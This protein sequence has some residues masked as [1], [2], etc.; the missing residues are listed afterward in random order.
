MRLSFDTLRINWLSL[1]VFSLFNKNK[2]V[3]TLS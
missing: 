3:V 2:G 1:T